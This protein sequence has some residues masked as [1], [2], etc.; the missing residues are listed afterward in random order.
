MAIAFLW[1]SK[2]K[3]LLL[4]KYIASLLYQHKITCSHFTIVLRIP[5]F[6]KLLIR[7]RDG[8]NTHY[9]LSFSKEKQKNY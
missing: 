8:K 6:T 3:K 4:L 5:Y 7:M 1:I 9:A 2:K